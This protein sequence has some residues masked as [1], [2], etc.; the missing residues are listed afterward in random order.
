M[1]DLSNDDNL[2]EEGVI[3]ADAFSVWRGG[4][5][6]WKC[7]K[8]SNVYAIGISDEDL[9]MSVSL[10]SPQCTDA[11]KSISEIYF[12]DK[13][14]MA[15]QSYYMNHCERCGV[16]LGDWFLH[17]EPD[18]CFFPGNER[19]KIATHNIPLEAQAGL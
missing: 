8:L 4:Y 12:P 1:E 10:L 15:N 18:G 7:K 5:E 19:T 3:R 16:K 11:L 9:L 2:T 17:A 6:C 13:S 14:A